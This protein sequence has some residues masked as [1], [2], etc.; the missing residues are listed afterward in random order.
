M[1][2]SRTALEM[3]QSSAACFYDYIQ[4]SMEARYPF[5]NNSRRCLE[6]SQI[7]MD[8]WLLKA[9]PFSQDISLVSIVLSCVVPS[10]T[11]LP[12]C[13]ESS[14][15]CV[16]FWCLGTFDVLEPVFSSSKHWD[17][18]FMS[19]TVSVMALAVIPSTNSPQPYLLSAS[20]T[21]GGEKSEQA[22][23]SLRPLHPALVQSSTDTDSICDDRAMASSNDGESGRDF[24][25]LSD[26]G[27]TLGADE[28]NQTRIVVSSRSSLDGDE[29]S[30][31]GAEAATEQRPFHRWIKTLHRRAQRS[32]IRD[33]DGRAE[34]LRGSLEEDLLSNRRKSSSESSFQYVA[35][36][37][38]ASVSIAGSVMTRSKQNAGWPSHHAADRNSRASMSTGRRSEDSIRQERLSIDP[39]V[40]ERLLQRRRILE[41]LIST[42]ESYIGDVKFLMNVYITILASLPTQQPGLRS[43][44][45]RNL[46]DIVELHEEIL[47][48]LHRVVPNSEYT[49]VDGKLPIQR[50]IPAHSH[51]RWRSLDSVPENKGGTSWLQNLPSMTADPEVAAKVSRV[52]GIR[53]HRFFVYEEYGAKYEMM[54][55]DVASAPRTMPQ[56]ETYQRG[57]EALAASLGSINHQLDHS[58]K[59]LTIGDLLVKPIQRI[60][61]YPLLFA[62]LLKYTPVYDCPTSH[63]EIENVLVRLREATSE[64]NRA[65][66]DPGVKATMERTWLLQDRLSLPDQV[67]QPI[68]SRLST[69]NHVQCFTSSAKMTIRSLGQNRLC[70]ALHV[71]WQT[72]DGVKGEYMICLLYKDC[73]CLATTSS[74]GDQVYTIQACIGLSTIKIEEADNG[75]GLQCHTAPFSWKLVFEIDYQLYEVIMTACSPKEEIEWRSRLAGSIPSEEHDL[76]EPAWTSSLY[77]NIKSLGTVFGKPGKGT[78]ARRLSIHRATTVGPKSPLC[79][80]ILKNTT[81]IKDPSSTVSGPSINR[82]QSL[83]TTNSRIPVLAPSRSE[84][85]R[86]EALLAD[87]WSRKELPFPGI[88]TRSKSEHIVRS[89]ASTVMRK[90]S[91]ASIANSLTK[92]SASSASLGSSSNNNNEKDDD[93]ELP[94]VNSAVE[95]LVALNSEMNFSIKDPDQELDDAHRLPPIDDE[96]ERTKSSNSGPSS[97]GLPSSHARRLHPT[98]VGIER[99][100]VSSQA[101]RRVRRAPALRTSSANSISKGKGRPAS[102]KSTS[103]TSGEKENVIISTETRSPAPRGAKNERKASS[104]WSKVGHLLSGWNSHAQKHGGLAICFAPLYLPT[105]VMHQKRLARRNEMIARRPVT[106]VL[107]IWVLLDST[108]P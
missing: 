52:F 72:R 17:F 60:C 73:L 30:C 92:R 95:S 89:S 90:L 19:L 71:C 70:G 108:T 46:T 87:V 5:I 12:L 48:D 13:F 49:Q 107:T 88:T 86:L 25:K 94:H 26:I 104:R 64:I 93:N 1:S 33:I 23:T 35:G 41:E 31:E 9:G 53:M 77:L 105:I 37:R 4:M 63:A 20:V 67:F 42:E 8:G 101:H 11:L 16:A 99:L 65:T 59:S 62:E 54:I 69:A 102:A 7:H 34:P 61:K 98:S 56:W 74:R 58:K 51:R 32:R 21:G 78:V 45:N 57:L 15:A 29:C 47:G 43:S 75:R 68:F 66:D 18:L 82:S 106:F 55:K 14:P 80:V 79:Q 3:T 83:L 2:L 28:D 44:I 39:A 6:T 22:P 76:G 91:V 36:I 96:T 103:P 85:A 100:E 40:T 84:R 97:D 38:S 10:T 50:S 27:E 81:T 24:D